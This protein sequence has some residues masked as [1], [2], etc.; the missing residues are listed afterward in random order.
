M[1]E[2]DEMWPFDISY[3]ISFATQVWL[4]IDNKNEK[5]LRWNMLIFNTTIESIPMNLNIKLEPALQ[6]VKHNV[7]YKIPTILFWSLH[8]FH[9]A[10]DSAVMTFKSPIYSAWPRRRLVVVYQAVTRHAGARMMNR[11]LPHS[12]MDVEHKFNALTVHD[13]SLLGSLEIDPVDVL[14]WR[15]CKASLF[16]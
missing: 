10:H 4:K 5:N 12:L 9:T 16:F 15:N 3:T 11:K 14:N 1:T 6:N 13:F 8:I 7:Y 2:Q